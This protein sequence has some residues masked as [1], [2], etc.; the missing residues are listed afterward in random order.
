MNPVLAIGLVT[1][2]FFVT[3]LLIVFLMS[4]PSREAKRV[5]NV[6]RIPKTSDEA[7][8]TLLEK[9]RESLHFVRA[10][11][12]FKED[13]KLR[14]RLIAAGHNNPGDADFYFASRILGPLAAILCGT[15]IPN[16]MGLWILGM[17]L[18][19][20]L[21]PDIVLTEMMRHRREKIRLGM[22]DAIDL[23]VICVEA[24]LGLD[25]ALLR[26]GQELMLS[27]PEISEEFNQINLEQRAGKARLDA[28]RSM[29]ERTRL[30]LI[31][32]FVSM[33]AQCDRFGTPIAR[34]L[35][36]FSDSLR[37]KRRQQAEEMA[38]K[39]TVKLIFPLV[40][41]IFPSIF[42]VLLGPA[43]ITIMKSF[44]QGFVK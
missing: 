37:L 38:A 26:S 28:W 42:I 32:G 33:L 34:A 10:K 25:Q 18:G 41:F 36:I 3:A 15:F 24:G 20:Y 16:N 39:T 22:P 29:A 43:A 14:Q 1:T 23:L 13:E 12:G 9:I 21:L 8:A 11:L 40:L 7:E 19:A 5:F 6:T 30:D 35:T 44:Q 27:H 4:R 2:G 31:R 17:A